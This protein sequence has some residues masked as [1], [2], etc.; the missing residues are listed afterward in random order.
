MLRNV[1]P[2]FNPYDYEKK[3]P[4]DAFGEEAGP[5]AR[6]WWTY[7]D[8]AEE[9]DFERIEGWKDTIDVLLIFVCFVPLEVLRL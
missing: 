2:G 6:V 4:E 5:N 9:F 7:L 3:Y 1:H 8:V